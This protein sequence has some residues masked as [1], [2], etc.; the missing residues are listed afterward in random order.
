MAEAAALGLH[1]E[2]R[3]V[4]A[5]GDR[6]V[7]KLLDT[8][9][10]SLRILQLLDRVRER[11]LVV[12]AFGDVGGDAPHA[13]ELLVEAGDLAVCRDDEDAVRGGLERRF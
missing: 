6:I 5:L 8:L 2:L 7:V 3:H 12:A 4:E 11:A 10:E 9:E 13:N 1:R